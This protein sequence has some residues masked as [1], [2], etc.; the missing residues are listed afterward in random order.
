MDFGKI[1]DQWEGLQPE[2]SKTD[3]YDERRDAVVTES[4]SPGMNR[5]KLRKMKPQAELDLHGLSVEQAEPVLDDFIRTSYSEGHKKI[6]IIH[7]KGLH[8]PEKPILPGMVRKYIE[9]SPQCGEFG[10]A[11]GSEGGSGVLWVLLR[12]RSR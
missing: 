8:S 4:A 3:E 9:K 11:Q 5:K 2:E 12:Y 10:Y 6:H 1:L 7:G